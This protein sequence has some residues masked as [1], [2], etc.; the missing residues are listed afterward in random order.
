MSKPELTVK[1]T[2]TIVSREWIDERLGDG[3]FHQTV[4]KKFPDWP[5][6]ILPG[7]YYPLRPQMFVWRKALGRIDGY[8]DV[9]SMIRD[10]AAVT[11]ER[12][13]NSIYKAFLWAASPH[14]FLRAVPRLWSSYA[15]FGAF[16]TLENVP[17]M[18]RARISEIPEEL[19]DWAA[20]SLAGFLRP[21]L[22]LA[23]GTSPDSQITDR[24]ASAGEEWEIEYRLGY[25]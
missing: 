3:F 25:S 22:L 14:L 5:Q 24:R 17:G 8:P 19:L 11:A 1:G 6:R 20:G 12:D 23:G 7:E 9:E 2:P 13:L 16:E 21:A 18:Y 4:T 15:R 10:A